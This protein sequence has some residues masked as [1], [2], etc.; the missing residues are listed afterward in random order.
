MNPRGDLLSRVL[1]FGLAL[2]VILAP[3]PFGAVVPGGRLALE[4]G[5]ASL[6]C[7]WIVRAWRHPTKLPPRSVVV[8]LLGLL[9][10]AL[11]QTLPLPAAVAEVVAPRATLLRLE[12]QPAP[13]IVQTEAELLGVQPQAFHTPATVSL[14]SWATTSALR[15]GVAIVALLLIATTVAA[16]R[17]VRMLAVALLISAAFQGLYGMLILLS[18]YDQIWHLPKKYS[19]G[20]ATGTFVNRNHFACMLAMSLACGAALVMHD[21]QATRSRSPRRWQVDLLGPAGSKTILM[22]LML[23]VGLAGLL[24]SFSRAGIATGLLALFVTLM[25]HRFGRLRI[26]LGIALIVG[27]FAIVPLV[28]IGADRLLHRFEHSAESLQQSG[29]RSTVWV[30][31]L[32]VA[33]DFPVLGSGFGTF[34]EVYPFYRSDEVRLFYKHAHNDLLQLVA[35][36]GIAGLFLLLLVLVPVGAGIFAG[37]GGSK[38]ILG[39]GFAAGLAAVLMHSLIDFN[40]HIPSNAAIAAILAGALMG[41]PWIV[42]D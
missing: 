31:T 34:A 17:G 5:A 38:G 13:E 25:A 12:A 32:S 42:R 7:V 27:A 41:L 26:R 28:Q 22:G 21:F 11:L 20:S 29:G 18:G 24:T 30:D 36:S 23:V 37:I 40:F 3:M 8:G 2:I 39:A 15:T 10:L 4:V 19:L 16:E 14:D 33:A 9:S 35:E 6:L 1:E